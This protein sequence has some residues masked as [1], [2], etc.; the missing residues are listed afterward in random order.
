MKNK[1][2][3]V[4]DIKAE[5][6]NLPYFATN[7]EVAIRSFKGGVNDETTDLARNPEDYSLHY[8]GEYDMETGM[9]T[10][11]GPKVIALAAQFGGI[12]K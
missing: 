9:I 8:L 2:Y 4:H 6:F 12:N 10:G 5:I 3:A 1:I 11:E 7:D